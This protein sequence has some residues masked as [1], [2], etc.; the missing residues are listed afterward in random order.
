MLLVCLCYS[1]H[2]RLL[3]HQISSCLATNAIAWVSEGE[4][5]YIIFKFEVVVF[6]GA[7][8]QHVHGFHSIFA[9]NIEVGECVV[10]TTKSIYIIELVNYEQGWPGRV[11]V[12]NTL[13]NIKY[14]RAGKV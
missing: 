8:K 6:G 13:L 4:W 11:H 10:G 5:N 2:Y 3:L 9:Y 14:P 1:L 12:R 7:V